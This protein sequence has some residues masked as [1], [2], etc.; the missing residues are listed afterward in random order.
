TISLI[1]EHD[2]A[3]SMFAAEVDAIISRQT[4]TPAGYNMTAG[5]EGVLDPTGEVSR[6]RSAVIKRMFRDDAGYAARHRDGVR[7]FQMSE[8]GQALRKKMGI[9]HKG[10]TMHPNAAKAI[11]AAKQTDEYRKIASAATKKTWAKE[12]YKESWVKAKL[13]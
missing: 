4:M 5:G 6:K 1:S 8:A 11:Y 3:D 9:L 2:N 7:R 13:A 10:K 12:G